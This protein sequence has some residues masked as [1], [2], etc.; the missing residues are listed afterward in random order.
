MLKR[1]YLQI[2]LLCLERLLLSADDVNIVNEQAF[3]AERS[4]F[5][6]EKYPSTKVR[7]INE[8]TL[9]PKTNSLESTSKGIPPLEDTVLA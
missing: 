4:I 7:N 8:I 2:S 6:S 1:F 3:S 5:P 9:A